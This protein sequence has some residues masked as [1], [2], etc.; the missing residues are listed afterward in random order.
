MARVEKLEDDVL[1]VLT[2]E[3]ASLLKELLGT[4]TASVL[5]GLYLGMCEQKID[6]LGQLTQLA[7]GV[8]HKK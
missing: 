3:E 5:S 2:H 1:I 4:Y 7:N 8:I 6:E